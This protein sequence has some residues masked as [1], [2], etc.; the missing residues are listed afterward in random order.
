M[1]LFEVAVVAAMASRA[2]RPAAKS[3]T[4]FRSVAESV[5]PCTCIFPLVSALRMDSAGSA[6]SAVGVGAE[7]CPSA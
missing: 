3:A 2:P 5:E 6:R 4:A 7:V 1:H